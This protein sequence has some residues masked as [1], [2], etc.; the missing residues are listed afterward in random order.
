LD[1]PNN[2]I[3]EWES[4]V[5]PWIRQST[6]ENLHVPDRSKIIAT[7]TRNKSNIGGL[8]GKELL[9]DQL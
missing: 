7:N 1:H 9:P 8:E 5:T 6:N 4:N 3:W 2:G